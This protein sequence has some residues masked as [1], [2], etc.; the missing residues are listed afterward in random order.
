MNKKKTIKERIKEWTERNKDKI[1]IGAMGTVVL[2]L[3]YADIKVLYKNHKKLD[4]E[5][6]DYDYDL[7]A[8]D[9]NET[10]VDDPELLELIRLEKEG[11]S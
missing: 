3:I 8:F 4:Y 9:Y 1:I 7:D 6:P 2:G 5:E 10:N 11:L